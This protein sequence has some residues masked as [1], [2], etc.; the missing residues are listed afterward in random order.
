MFAK[1]REDSA[2]A[3]DKCIQHDMQYWKLSKL[4]KE[5]VDYDN[6]VQVLKENFVT[7]K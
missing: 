6:T 2:E 3:V 1:W 5:K 4:I 7:L